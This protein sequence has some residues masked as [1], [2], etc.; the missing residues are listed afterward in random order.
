MLR[1]KSSYKKD[2]ETPKKLKSKEKKR[3]KVCYLTKSIKS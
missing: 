1:Q 3:T 2:I